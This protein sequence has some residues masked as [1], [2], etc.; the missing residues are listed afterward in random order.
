M[1][2]M[3]NHR[4]QS[5]RN[6]E[7]SNLSVFHI[8][9]FLSWQGLSLPENMFCNE[10]PENRRILAIINFPSSAIRS[11]SVSANWTFATHQQM[12]LLTALTLRS[13]SVFLR[14]HCD[15][16]LCV[17]HT[18]DITYTYILIIILIL[19]LIHIC[20]PILILVNRC[21]SSQQ[22]HSFPQNN[23]EISITYTYTYTYNYSETYTYTYTYTFTHQQM[24]CGSQCF[25]QEISI[26]VFCI[27]STPL[28]SLD[29][30]DHL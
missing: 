10:G 5:I 22:Q 8:P 24:Q 15:L 17:L 19:K 30:T 21:N 29:L 23:I 1:P 7:E 14:K 20:I 12:Q 16:Y 3:A 26:S 28:T 4:R 27:P 11:E 6:H 9:Y 25:P 13:H 2:K 18:L